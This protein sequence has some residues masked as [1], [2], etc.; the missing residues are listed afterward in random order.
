MHPVFEATADEVEASL[1][2]LATMRQLPLEPGLSLY[3][4][5]GLYEFRE[6][7]RPEVGRE[8]Y[9]RA[10]GCIYAYEQAM[11]QPSEHVALAMYI[12]A[13]E[14]LANPNTSWR[15]NRSAARFVHFIEQLASSEIDETMSH[16]NFVQAFGSIASRKKFLEKLYELRST[17]L[18]TGMLRHAVGGFFQTD[19]MASIR[20]SLVS[21][22]VRTCFANFLRGPFSSLV[23]HPRVDPAAGGP[24]RP[25]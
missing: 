17:P 19:T 21:G 24:F 5:E 1:A 20:V 7:A 25:D 14:A 10:E 9:A 6:D 3:D 12:S 23:G 13:L 18:H 22:L 11:E 15:K 8:A 16:P 2:V 4:L